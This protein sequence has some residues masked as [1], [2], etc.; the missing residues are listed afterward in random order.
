MAPVRYGPACQKD[1]ES[2]ASRNSPSLAVALN[3]GIGSSRL[4][5][6]VN[7]FERLQFADHL[8]VSRAR[9]EAQARENGLAKDFI[10]HVL[11]S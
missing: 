1:C 7:V 11:E 10:R 9:R 8:P 3:C 4:N 5:A 2:R 6:E